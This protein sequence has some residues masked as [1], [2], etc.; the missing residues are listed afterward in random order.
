MAAAVDEPRIKTAVLLTGYYP[1][2]REKN[3]LISRKLP[4]FY[5]I[6]SNV[7]PFAR[8][9]TEL[10]NLTRQEGSELLV[11]EGGGIGY[12]FFRL[13]NNLVPRIARWMSEKLNRFKS[14]AGI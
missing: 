2:E 6:T 8:E 3:Y 7:E 1:T 11:Y 9:V 12:Q 10:Y 5:I 13:D 4:V 14:C